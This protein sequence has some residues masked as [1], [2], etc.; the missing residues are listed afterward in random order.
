MQI[1]VITVSASNL[2]HSRAFYGGLHGLVPAE[3]FD[4]WQGYQLGGIVG[5]LGIIEAPDLLRRASLDII[6]LTVEGLDPLWR[7]IR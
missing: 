2:E 5:G 1:Q 7:Q 6:N 4:R 3:S